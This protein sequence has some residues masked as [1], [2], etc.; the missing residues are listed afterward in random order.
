MSG[1]QSGLSR[2]VVVVGGGISG[3]A[4]AHRLV[5]SSSHLPFPLEVQLLEA[6]G[7]LG[8]VIQTA[9]GEGFLLEGGP[10]SFISEKPWALDLSQRLGLGSHLIGSNKDY[11]R[12][13]IVRRG[14][15]LPVPAGFYLLAPTQ[16]WPFLS[17]PIFSW[18]G[19]LRMAADLVLPRKD[20][21]SDESLANFVRRR[22]GQE[23]LDRMAQPMV[24]GIYT[25]DPEQLSLQ[26]TMPRFL[27]MERRHR[28][29]ILGIL[30]QRRGRPSVKED[31]LG[32]PR[33][34]LFVSFDQGMQVLVDSLQIR[35]P[36]GSVCL[37]RTVESLDRNPSSGL[38]VL[39]FR[40]GGRLEAD[41]V[42]LALASY[43][44]A[45]LVQHLDSTL[46]EKL[47][48]VPYAST[49]TV[50]LAYRR[51]AI[52]HPLDGFG[53]VVPAIERRQILACTFCHVKFEGRAR[54]DQAL[55]R[56]FV[57]GALQPAAFELE[58]REMI[59]VVRQELQD[60]LG[61]SAEPLFHRVE[62][63]LK[64]MA[65]YQVGHLEWVAEVESRIQK[66][67][68]L[69]LAGNAFTGVGIPDCVHRGEECADR[70]LAALQKNSPPNL[71]IS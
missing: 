58:D 2:R 57:G 5:E 23:A 52:P 54:K 70:I 64:A 9:H 24:G 6:S 46:S 12:S 26:A 44:S 14:R 29:V 41:A 69:Q 53:F 65:Q 32:G 68:A 50:N 8:G 31:R 18:R 30:C 42:C 4:A 71:R 49:A 25:S 35:L 28:S 40:D 66:H 37:N 48:L 7:R 59:R 51:D 45:K 36:V 15:L 47:K 61:V 17:T 11:R 34:S 39:N 63:H 62:R 67:P 10:D 13:F 20:A 56:A 21:N 43:Q 55:L 1:R 38:W 33:Y 22:L 27:E 19:K 60:L 16:I 3:L